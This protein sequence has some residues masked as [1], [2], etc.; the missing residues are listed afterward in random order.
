MIKNTESKKNKCGLLEYKIPHSHYMRK[1]SII[2]PISYSKRWKTKLSELIKSAKIHQNRQH[3]TQ[4]IEEL[5]TRLATYIHHNRVDAIC[6]IP[7]KNLRMTQLMTQV[8]N[9]LKQYPVQMIQC[10]WGSE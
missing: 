7:A 4:I 3:I 10:S 8:K 5:E 9:R 2:E 1:V 6:V